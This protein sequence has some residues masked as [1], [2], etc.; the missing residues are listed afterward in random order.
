[1][2]PKQYDDF[3]KTT[4]PLSQAP[5]RARVEM[6]LLNNDAESTLSAADLATVQMG[7][8]YDVGPND[9]AL[10]IIADR[11]DGATRPTVPGQPVL[12]S[13]LELDFLDAMHLAAQRHPAPR[14]VL[15]PW[16]AAVYWEDFRAVYVERHPRNS[17]DHVLQ[18][19]WRV[20][21]KLRRAREGLKTKGLIVI[22]RDGDRHL[23]WRTALQCCRVPGGAK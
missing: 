4:V 1:M 7:E 12:V 10:Q 16:R 21:A 3:R 17:G 6:A 5:Y 11:A 13:V 9:C 2:N 20:K 15:L 18:Y 14:P 19:K 8:Q 23:L 22:A